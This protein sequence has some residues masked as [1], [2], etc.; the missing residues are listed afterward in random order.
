M[1]R[2]QDLLFTSSVKEEPSSKKRRRSSG[3]SLLD[4]VKEIVK[5]ESRNF[6]YDFTLKSE[7]DEPSVKISVIYHVLARHSGYSIS[8]RA[9]GVQQSGVFHLFDISSSNHRKG[10]TG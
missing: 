3:S 10:Y 2:L 5:N 1:N 8:E 7:I 9:V 6:D 4:K